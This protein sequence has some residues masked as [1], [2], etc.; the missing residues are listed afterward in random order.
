MRLSLRSFHKKDFLFC[1]NLLNIARGVFSIKALFSMVVNIL[2]SY[3]FST[4]RGLF[5]GTFLYKIILEPEKKSEKNKAS[6]WQ[7]FISRDFLCLQGLFST[8]LFQ[9][10]NLGLHFRKKNFQRTFFGGYQGEHSIRPIIIAQ[11][12]NNLS[13]RPLKKCSTDPN[14]YLKWYQA[15][16]INSNVHIFSS[17]FHQRVRKFSSCLPVHCWR[18]F[19]KGCF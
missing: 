18:C 15:K 4:S 10:Q 13:I 3:A 9:C 2:C 17:F 16:L 8:G 1:I 14:T 7:D 6:K 11:S 19:L 5:P 12:W